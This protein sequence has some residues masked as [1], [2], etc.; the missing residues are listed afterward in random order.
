[1]NN[2]IFLTKSMLSFGF[3]PSLD[4]FSYFKSCVIDYANANACVS[5][6]DLYK[7]AAAKFGS[8][9]S[10]VE[11]SIRHSISVIPH[12]SDGINRLFGFQVNLDGVANKDLI[13]LFAEYL[14]LNEAI[15]A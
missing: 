10:K 2:E 6:S 7:S 15:D 4:G 14:K 8:T 1:M 5:I 3:R 13:A 9:P 12:L 11:R